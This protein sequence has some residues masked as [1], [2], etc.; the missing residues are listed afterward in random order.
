MGIRNLIVISKSEDLGHVIEN[1]VYLELIRRGYKV[2]VG[3]VGDAE[4]DFIATGM[5][6]T[7]YIQ[8]SAT[9]LHKKTLDRELKSLKD[10]DDNHEKILLTLD[11]IGSNSNHNGIIQKNLLEWLV[12]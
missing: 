10:I 5:N 2:N 3:K 12:E 8:V 9:V 7:V 6:K 11:E 4:V 1:I